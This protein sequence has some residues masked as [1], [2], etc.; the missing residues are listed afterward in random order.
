M[1][2]LT[3]IA[4]LLLATLWPLPDTV[5]LSATVTAQPRDPAILLLAEAPKRPIQLVDRVVEGSDFD[6]FRDRL[7]QA[8]QQR[9]E[10]FVRALLPTAG[11]FINQTGP[12]PIAR[13]ALEDTDS[14]FWLG[15]EKMLA[16][17]SCELEDYPG[18]LPDSAVWG[19]PNIASALPPPAPSATVPAEAALDHQVAVVGQRVNVRVR[20]RLGTSVV[21]K[22]SNE[23]VEFDLRAWQELQETA[24]ITAQNSIEGWTPVIL[25]NQVQGYV[26]NRYVYHPQGPRVLFELVAG[27][28]QLQRIVT[29]PTQPST[30]FY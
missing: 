29:D 4:P 9:D 26:H 15:L 28:W 30:L 16:P 6:E 14:P 18:T 24:P 3:A 23:V 13:L 27:Q 20:P 22:L 8:I 17:Q 25:P 19:C 10:V 2:A 1:T 7:W 11:I 5:A 12:V 21:G